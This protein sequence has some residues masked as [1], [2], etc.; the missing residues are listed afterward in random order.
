MSVRDADRNRLRVNGVFSLY[1]Q[2][3]TT[4][5]KDEFFVCE[6]LAVPINLGSDINDEFVQRIDVITKQLISVHGASVALLR[7]VPDNLHPLPARPTWLEGRS[8]DRRKGCGRLAG[9]RWNLVP[10]L[11]LRLQI[12]RRGDADPVRA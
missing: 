11:G 6:K 9:P 7:T 2:L 1:V 12:R 10:R 5:M 4:L 3:E 8:L